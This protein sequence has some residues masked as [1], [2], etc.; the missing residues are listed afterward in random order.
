MNEHEFMD[1]FIPLKDRTAISCGIMISYLFAVFGFIAA[2]TGNPKAM[3]SVVYFCVCGFGLQKFKSRISAVMLIA[4]VLVSIGVFLY[5]IFTE[6]GAGDIKLLFVIGVLLP[7]AGIF[8]YI[9]FDSGQISGSN[10]GFVKGV[11]LISLVPAVIRYHKIRADYDNGVNA[12]F[13]EGDVPMC[14]PYEADVAPIELAENT[15][16]VGNVLYPTEEPE[17]EEPP[18]PLPE[19]SMDE[20]P[21]YPQPDKYADPW[22]MDDIRVDK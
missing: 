12:E 15:D 2:V 21:T 8:S 1:R 5:G 13:F 16:D 18:V 10:S 9:K 4:G 3:V 11:L 22:E 14:N 17:A 7:A 6:F 20:L 19:Y